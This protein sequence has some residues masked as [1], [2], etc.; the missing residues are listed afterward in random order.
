MFCFLFYSN[1]VC[2][3]YCIIQILLLTYILAKVQI[4][5]FDRIKSSEIK[6]VKEKK[7]KVRQGKEWWKCD[8]G[9]YIWKACILQAF[10]NLE[11]NFQR[12][13]GFKDPTGWL[14]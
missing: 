10:R 13:L 2:C 1:H 7:I 4:Y 11:D 9:D 3:N 12:D 14:T 8:R 5:R 6:H